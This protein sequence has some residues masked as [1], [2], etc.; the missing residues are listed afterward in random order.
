MPGHIDISK[1]GEVAGKAGG[2]GGKRLITRNV[3]RG[4]LL[5]LS[6]GCIRQTQ[7]PAC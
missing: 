7:N 3:Q 5:L 4:N 1:H 6:I 2:G